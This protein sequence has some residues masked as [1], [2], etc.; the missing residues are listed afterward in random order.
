MYLL[1]KSIK[2]AITMSLFTLFSSSVVQANPVAECYSNNTTLLNKSFYPTGSSKQ[3]GVHKLFVINRKDGE[4]LALDGKVITNDKGQY[5]GV[6][7]KDE[8]NSFFFPAKKNTRIMHNDKEELFQVGDCYLFYGSFDKV[9]DNGIETGSIS[10]GRKVREGLF[11]ND[12]KFKP[13]F[14]CKKATALIEK[15]ICNDPEIS[16]L[17]KYYHETIDE[18]KVAAENSGVGKYL[19]PMLDSLTSDFMAYRDKSFA[20]KEEK[21]TNDEATQIKK[22][23]MLGIMF[24]PMTVSADNGWIYLLGKKLFFS[25]YMLENQ[26]IK[27]SKAPKK[28]FGMEKVM[29]DMLGVHYDEII[30]NYSAVYDNL[31]SRL[32]NLFYYTYYLMEKYGMINRVGKYINNNKNK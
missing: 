27:Y 13:S 29:K 2:I 3:D 22:A 26:G 23:Y 10:Y 6:E 20:G 28:G 15:A 25:Y 17:D 32:P 30:Y 31:N 24:I 18:I 19:I 5:L 7:F 9:I 14:D 4:K 16:F 11:S 8:S 1:K 12:A 21:F